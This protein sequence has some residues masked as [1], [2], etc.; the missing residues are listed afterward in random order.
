MALGKK[1]SA[2]IL[3]YRFRG[4]R[5]QVLLVHPGGPYWARKDKGSWMIPKGEVKVGENALEAAVREFREEIGFEVNGNFIDLGEVRQSGGKL[6]HVWALEKDVDVKG[7]KSNT[8]IMEWPKDSGI[9]R[10]FPEVDKAAWFDI[11]EAFKKIL[12]SQKPFLE[13]LIK[14]LNFSN[15]ALKPRPEERKTLLDYFHQGFNT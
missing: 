8:F 11:N 6:V 10:E 2:G 9:L 4:G 1:F 12:T 7:V 13:R 3:L 15:Q 14:V 5:L